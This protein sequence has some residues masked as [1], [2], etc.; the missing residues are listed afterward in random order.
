MKRLF[1]AAGLLA[2]VSTT[3]AFS[4][5]KIPA[6]VMISFEQ[7][8]SKATQVVYTEINEMVRVEFFHGNEKNVAYYN[9]T[10]DLIVLT[11]P[12]TLEQLPISLQEDLKKRYSDYS[13][14]D[15]QLFRKDG[16]VEYF[17]FADSAKKHLILNAPGSRWRI[18]K[19]SKK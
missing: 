16:R 1:V 14:S 17:V 6:A 9:S 5:D 8:F 15:V 13:I 7:N 19:I 11:Q 10:G 2:I 12:I 18:F 4:A 3:S